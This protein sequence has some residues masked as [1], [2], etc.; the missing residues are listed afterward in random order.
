MADLVQ[1]GIVVLIG[2]AALAFVVRQWLRRLAPRPAQ[3]SAGCGGCT[4]CSGSGCG[5]GP[6]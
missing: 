5:P 6:R 3:K 4:G 1:G 2:A